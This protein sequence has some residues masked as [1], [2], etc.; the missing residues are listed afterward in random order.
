MP[1]RKVILMYHS[2]STAAVPGVLGSFPLPLARFRHQLSEAQSH[3]WRFGRVSELREPVTTHTLCITG[4]DGTVDWA[5]NVLP[6][7]EEHGIP[8]HTGLIT[9]PWQAEP[10]YPVAHHLQILLSLPGGALPTPTL[11]AD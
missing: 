5:Q 6:W 7:C 2:V 1:F 4:D 10:I 8:T 3:G 9:G 11:T